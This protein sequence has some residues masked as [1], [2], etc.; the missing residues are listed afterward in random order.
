M[1][2]IGGYYPAGTAAKTIK[3]AFD[4]DK[5]NADANDKVITYIAIVESNDNA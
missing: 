1:S 3:V 4:K 2:T 5:L